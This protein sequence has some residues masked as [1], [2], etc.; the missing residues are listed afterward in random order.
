MQRKKE[1]RPSL[2]AN[3]RETKYNS[4]S[5]AQ[6]NVDCFGFWFGLMWVA[7]VAYVSFSEAGVI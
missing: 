5:I 3:G 7:V 2:P 4:R 1:T 6:R